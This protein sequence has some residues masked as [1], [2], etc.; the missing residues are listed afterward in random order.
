MN[1]EKG[2]FIVS[3][4]GSFTEEITKKLAE[5]FRTNKPQNSWE[6]FLFSLTFR[7]GNFFG[8]HQAS[9]GNEIP[10]WNRSCMYKYCKL[11]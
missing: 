4:V 9:E 1:S 6:K 3:V 5:H 7:N 11:F 8:S 2:F 10:P